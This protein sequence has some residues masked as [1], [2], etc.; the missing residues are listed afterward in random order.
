MLRPSATVRRAEIIALPGFIDRKYVR[1]PLEGSLFGC[2][3]I[4]LKSGWDMGGSWTDSPED[5]RLHSPKPQN[6]WDLGK[7]PSGHFRHGS[8]PCRETSS[9]RADEDVS[10]STVWECHD[11]PEGQT[12]TGWQLNEDMPVLVEIQGA[13][14]FDFFS[15]PGRI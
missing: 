14:V 2:E 9:E 12:Q 6:P 7:G 11:P 3:S 10:I 1:Q 13:S 8:S 4:R 15:K 5:R